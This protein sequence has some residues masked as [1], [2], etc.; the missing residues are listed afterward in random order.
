[1]LMLTANLLRNHV[2]SLSGWL[3]FLA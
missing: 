1:M 3:H 2:F